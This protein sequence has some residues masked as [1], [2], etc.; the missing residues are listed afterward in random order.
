[1]AIEKLPVNFRDDVIDTSISDKRRYNIIE[2]P[3]GTKSLEDVTAYAQIG[4]TKTDIKNGTIIAKEAESAKKLT[5][6]RKINGVDFDGTK[7]ITVKDDTKVSKNE[8]FRLTNK[9]LLSFT[10]NVCVISDERIMSDSLA[11]V[12]FTTETISAAE[13]AVITVETYD[14]YIQFNAENAPEQAIKAS[15]KIFA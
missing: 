2:N 14:G 9:Q 12:Y 15:I 10:E 6:A 13:K 3:D 7:D 4:N 11:D 5:T 8:I 1:M